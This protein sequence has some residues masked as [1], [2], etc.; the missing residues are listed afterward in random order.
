MNALIEFEKC[1]NIYHELNNFVN[2]IKIC[3]NEIVNGILIKYKNKKWITGTI[4]NI[5]GNFTKKE[6]NIEMNIEIIIENNYYCYNIKCIKSLLDENISQ[7]TYENINN[8]TLFFDQHLN[9]F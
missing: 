8:E 9:L 1:K 6:M 7:N 2:N 3:D 4:M 5:D